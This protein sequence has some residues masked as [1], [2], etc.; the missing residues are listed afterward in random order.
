MADQDVATLF[1]HIAAQLAGLSTVVGMQ[2]ISQIVHPF[3]GDSKISKDWVRSKEKYASLTG[4][5]DD[6]VKMVAYQSSWV[7]VSDFI[8]RYLPDN[9]GSNWGQLKT[10][11]TSRFAEITNPQHA[12]VLL[13]KVKQRA[14]ENVQL[15]EERL[16]ALAE[17][18][19]AGQ[20][21]GVAAIERQLVGVF[22]DGLVHDNLKMRVMRANPATLQTS[23]A[24]AMTEQNLRKRFNLRIGR[25]TDSSVC[26]IE[27]MEIDHLQPTKHCFKYD[28]LGHYARHC[29]NRPYSNIEPMEFDYA[30]SP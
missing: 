3:E 6:R 29:H 17:E 25:V 1:Q 30:R 27:P 24:S 12:F 15:Y 16:L 4:L 23:V 26:H 7:A 28:K 14:D 9:V 18:A 2:G 21:G 5:T 8:Q 13:R 22:M 20:N 11:I 10:E 19:L